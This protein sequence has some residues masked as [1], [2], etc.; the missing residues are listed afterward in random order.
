[1]P[2]LRDVDKMNFADIELGLTELGEKVQLINFP[3]Q[4]NKIV[5][6]SDLLNITSSQVH[7]TFFYDGNS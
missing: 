1:M 4:I 7:L 6:Y 2:V 5:F 3:W